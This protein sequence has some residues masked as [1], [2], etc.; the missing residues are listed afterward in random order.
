MHSF[1]TPFEW[2]ACLYARFPANWARRF[3]GT[4][5]NTDPHSALRTFWRNVPDSDPRKSEL[6][7][8]FARRDDLES[9]EDGWSRAVPIVVHGDGVPCGRGSLDVFVLG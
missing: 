1:N 8:Y 5:D 2:F 9:P 7:A 4:D 6:L 3:L